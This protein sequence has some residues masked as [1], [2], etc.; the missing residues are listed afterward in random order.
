M[1]RT[2]VTKT[3]APGGYAGTGIILTQEAADTVNSNK[4]PATG[5]DIIVASNTDVGAQTVTI[6][7]VDD[8]YG[9]QENITA[10]SIPAGEIHIFGPFSYHGWQQSDGAI[11]LEASDATVKFSIIQL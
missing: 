2:A 10:Y 1:A 8:K 5:N 4:F 11:Y 7:S 9:R 6:T 3:V